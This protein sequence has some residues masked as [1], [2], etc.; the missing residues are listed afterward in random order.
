M[1]KECEAA[2]NDPVDLDL[3]LKNMAE[4]ELLA[5]AKNLNPERL[6]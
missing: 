5:P 6:Q 4:I 1:P 2:N 3:P